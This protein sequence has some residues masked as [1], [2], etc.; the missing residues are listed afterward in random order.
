MKYC[1]LILKWVSVIIAMK[2]K[3]NFQLNCDKL[4]ETRGVNVINY[5]MALLQNLPRKISQNS[6]PLAQFK[7]GS[8]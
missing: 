1:H 5:F 8:S 6:W 7:L 2:S 3:D 4:E